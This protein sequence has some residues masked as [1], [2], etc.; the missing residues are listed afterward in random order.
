MEFIRDETCRYVP[1]IIKEYS[2]GTIPR[3]SRNYVKKTTV[4]D[5]EWVMVQNSYNN[6][7]LN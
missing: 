1:A 6:V 7:W 3:I 5:I 2:K 4:I